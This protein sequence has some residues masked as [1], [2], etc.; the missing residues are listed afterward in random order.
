VEI[1]PSAPPSKDRLTRV[2][3]ELAALREEFE[4]FKKQ[5]G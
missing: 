5:F 1:P 4:Q 2:E 3:E